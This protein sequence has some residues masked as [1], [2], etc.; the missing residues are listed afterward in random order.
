MKLEHTFQIGEYLEGAQ[1]NMNE[2]MSDITFAQEVIIDVE[3]YLTR[4]LWVGELD[5]CDEVGQLC[6]NAYSMW[7]A[8]VMLA[9][10]GHPTAVPSVLR[11]GLESACYAV[12][13]H[14]SPDLAAVW[15][16]RNNDEDAL[17]LCKKHFS[18][19][20]KRS[21]DL[22]ES[23]RPGIGNIIYGRY[24]NTIDFGAH[25]NTLSI[26]HNMHREQ[27]SD[28]VWNNT[29]G[30]LYDHDAIQAKRGVLFCADI[31][32]AISLACTFVIDNASE[33]HWSGA[34]GNFMKF[35]AA[36]NF[37]VEEADSL[38]GSSS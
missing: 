35:H 12:L 19:A 22:M 32:T 4:E 33:W 21:T 26:V 20:I 25:P 10:G 7:L 9:A 24:E 3:R 15:R 27:L 5:I 28:D 30:I 29:F 31:G 17:R 13:I 1:Q 36:A 16:N 37:F 34:F 18:S 6:S 38:K 11:T 2:F 23:K 14:E 8:G